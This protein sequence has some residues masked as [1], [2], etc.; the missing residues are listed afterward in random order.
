[1]DGLSKSFETLKT[2]AE[3]SDASPD[4][5]QA[6][7]FAR[8]IKTQV[9]DELK[10]NNNLDELVNGVVQGV[11][12]LASSEIFL[13]DNYSA[14]HFSLDVTK[15]VGK[16]TAAYIQSLPADQRLGAIKELGQAASGLL[17]ADAQQ[18]MNQ[19]IT[20]VEGM[21]ADIQAKAID[22]VTEVAATG[23]LGDEAYMNGQFKQDAVKIASAGVS[24]YLAGIPEGQ[25]FQV[26]KDFQS[27]I[28]G[29]L[30]P[31]QKE[32]MDSFFNKMEQA[33]PEVQETMANLVAEDPEF[34]ESIG[35]LAVSNPAVLSS[36]A[37][38]LS[39]GTNATATEQI[40]AIKQASHL[41]END[42]LRGQ[43]TEMINNVANDPN[44]TDEHFTEVIEASQS[45]KEIALEA[46]LK[47]NFLHAVGWENED[48]TVARERLEN[49]YA[50]IGLGKDDLN[51]AIEQGTLLAI[52]NHPLM[53]LFNK[54]MNFIGEMFPG[55]TDFM[56]DMFKMLPD[57]WISDSAIDQA[58]ADMKSGEFEFQR[59]ELFGIE[60]WMAGVETTSFESGA[61]RN[62]RS[63]DDLRAE[64]PT[65]WSAKV[66]TPDAPRTAEQII[67]QAQEAARQ[68]AAQNQAGGVPAFTN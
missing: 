63:M 51:L 5:I 3:K 66:G 31:E 35:N 34:I 45:Y 30:S 8:L 41:L 11:S 4:S 32:Q 56:G 26:F 61:Q 18:Q 67:E 10:N 15:I 57:S 40:A 65:E 28:S 64:L 16:E 19:V 17:D 53:N 39:E 21:P 62:G 47:G 14:G 33:G 12:E 48:L 52:N 7:V 25:R 49:A 36:V 9:P 37:K 29:I 38:A 2:L 60:K 55:F 22:L 42:V 58:T 24:G 23:K 50:N 27:N 20:V 54:L 43:L 44:I 13:E 6:K 46:G 1:M 68:Y 59:S